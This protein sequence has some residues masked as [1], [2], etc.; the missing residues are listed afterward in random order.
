MFLSVPK[1]HSLVFALELSACMLMLYFLP[2]VPA[3]NKNLKK[4]KTLSRAAVKPTK[5]VSTLPKTVEDGLY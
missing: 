3:S 5:L 2:T 4:M 1:S